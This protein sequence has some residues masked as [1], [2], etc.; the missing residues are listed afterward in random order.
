MGLFRNCVFLCVCGINTCR[1][2]GRQ[3]TYILQRWHTEH[4]SGWEV[5]GAGTC[6][7]FWCHQRQGHC[8]CRSYGGQQVCVCARCV[9]VPQR[10]GMCVFTVC[11]YLREQV[12]GCAQ[13]VCLPERAGMCVCTFCV[14]TSV[15][16][17]MDQGV[18]HFG[19]TIAVQYFGF[20]SE[21]RFR[22][23]LLVLYYK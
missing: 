7:L 14:C 5:V 20:I 12:C 21:S 17:I 15:S 11:L 6:L 16:E 9:L 23:C 18:L 19:V 22:V 10:A 4:G 3:T 1:H 8:N 2:T 13:C